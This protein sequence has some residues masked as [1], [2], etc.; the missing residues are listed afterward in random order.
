MLHDF[1]YYGAAYFVCRCVL[2]YS[3]SVILVYYMILRN[4]S[5]VLI[6]FARLFHGCGNSHCIR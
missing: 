6:W 5:A 3:V 1:K 2:R 4:D